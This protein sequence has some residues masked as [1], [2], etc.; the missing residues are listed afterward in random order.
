[1]VLRNDVREIEGLQ[2]AGLDDLWAGEFA[3][4]P[5]LRRL[6]SSRASLVLSHNPDTVDSAGVGGRTRAGSCPA[7]RTAASASRRSCRRRSCPSAIGATR[8]GSSAS[9]GIGAFTS[10]GGS[11]T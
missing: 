5:A 10:A 8:P 1:M 6:D 11:V 7:T 2:I 3:P 4:L 9:L